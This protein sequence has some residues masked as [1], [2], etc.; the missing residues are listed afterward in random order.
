V[1]VL[2]AFIKPNRVQSMILW[3]MGDLSSS[4]FNLVKIGYFVILPAIVIIVLLSR[5][6]DILSLG[7]EKAHSLGLNVKKQKQCFYI[8]ASLITGTAIV[9]SGVVGFIGLLIPHLMRRFFGTLNRGV[10][11]ASALSGAA[12]LLLADTF[13]RVIISPLELPVGV[14]T[15][16]V[17][18]V[19][20][21]VILILGKEFKVG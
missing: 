4:N 17:G 9:L 15:G 10:L 18:G 20:F 5:K 19:F 11:I 14:V 16:L 8:L 13:A 7:D 6:L 2:F 12:F 1:L 21:L 3:L